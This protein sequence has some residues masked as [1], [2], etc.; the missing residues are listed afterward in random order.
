[1]N[2][3]SVNAPDRTTPEATASR[4]RQAR[5]DSRRRHPRLRRTR[6]FWRTGRRHRAA[7]GHRRRHR[8]PLLPK[9]GRTAAHALRAHHAGRHPRGPGGHE[10][11][12]TI[13]GFNGFNFIFQHFFQHIFYTTF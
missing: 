13:N 11:K 5:P 7:R 2:S 8:L 3:H 1:M 9:Q 10:M 4:R 6:L 12:L